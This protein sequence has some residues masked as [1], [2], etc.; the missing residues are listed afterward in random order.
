[1][2][3]N[4]DSIHVVYASDERFAPVLGVSIASLLITGKDIPSFDIT[5][6]DGG[7]SSDNR[8]KIDDLCRQFGRNPPEYLCLDD[9]EDLLGDRIGL[10]RGSIMQY[11]RLFIGRLPY[12]RVLYLD[13]DVMLRRSVSELWS[14]DLEGKTVATMPDVFSR[15]YRK[16]MEL[17]PEEPIYNDGVMLLDLEMWREHGIEEKALAFIRRCGGSPLQDDLGVINA[18]LSREALPLSPEWNSLT[19]FY[20]FTY[21]EMLYYR[22]PPAY[23]SKEEIS[24]AVSNPA[25]VHFTSSFRS[26]RPWEAGCTH[27]YAKEYEALRALTPWA[28]LPLR[29]PRKGLSS[30]LMNALPWSLAIHIAAPLQAYGRPIYYLLK[31]RVHKFG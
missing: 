10:D 19:A 30:R 13:C 1:M 9:M 8:Q 2:L 12:E 21:D 18:V 7:L 23:F 5:V 22:K 17:N 31:E 3:Q 27:P 15:L 26:V 4:P 20:D 11:A 25:L 6:F 28:D 24:R 16:G 14:K 29:Q